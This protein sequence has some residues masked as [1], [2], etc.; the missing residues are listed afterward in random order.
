LPYLG[1]NSLAGQHK[2]DKYRQAAA[3]R[4]GRRARQPVAAVD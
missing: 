1:F 4:A 3:V 2:R